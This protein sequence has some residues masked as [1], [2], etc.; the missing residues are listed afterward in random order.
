MSRLFFT[1]LG[2]LF[3]N[4]LSAQFC[5]TQQGPLLER[6]DVN[7]RS[8]QPAQRG[9]L[10]FVP[11]TFHLVA[12]SEG[13]GRI[14]EEAV[15]RQISTF[16]AQFADQEILFYIDRFNYFNNTA[17]YD[18]PGSSAARIQMNLRK[19]NNSVNIFIVNQ[20][21]LGGGGPGVTQAYYDSQGDWIV[22]RK[23]VVGTSS[24]LAHEVGHFFSLP[25]PHTGWDCH[26]WIPQE[27][28]N[29]V[30]VDFTIECDEGGGSVRI[31][32]QDGSNCSIA[33]DRICDTPPDYN[34]GLLH[35]DDCSPN[36]T[37]KDKNGTVIQ[38]IT[39]NFMGYYRGCDSYTFTPTQKN[40]ISTDYNSFQRSY[41]RLPKIPEQD[42]VNGPVNYITPING[43]ET[44]TSTNILFDWE[45][46]PNA[47]H[48]LLIID[49]FVSF[50]FNPTRV[51]VAESQYIMDELTEGAIFHWKVW[52][53]NE[54]QT[55]A[56]FSAPQNF[57]VGMG[58]GVNEIEDISDFS[59]TPNPAAEG[60]PNVLTLSSVNSFHA[61]L[62][63]TDASGH[64][65]MNQQLEIP[66]GIS[67]HQLNTADLSPG[68]YFVIL[69]SEKGILV[70]RILKAS[71]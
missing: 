50:T 31:E 61:D 10:K 33:G 54:S 11:V 45:D 22:S 1:L 19:D 6:L 47:T 34:L 2:L 60:Q 26:P 53:Y 38:P 66:S 40:L 42:P 69:E 13:V 62:S 43:I 44:S 16:N 63:I 29:P 3:V 58:T 51:I 27:Y 17:V 8:L 12:N 18:D 36:T 37:I 71:D 55:D 24:T 21:D 52:P 46:V 65:L 49:R 7:M 70:E 68:I 28:T 67:S 15:L 9:L 48:Y 4:L 35:Q 20:I 14:N 59:I 25:H 41:I 56:G 39:N 32:L 5:G 64:T 57:R 23:S 30:N